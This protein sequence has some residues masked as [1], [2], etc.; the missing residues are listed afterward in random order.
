[1][2]TRSKTLI[3]IPPG[4]TIKEQLDERNLTQKEFASRMEMSEKHISKLI[5]GEVQLTVDMAIRLEMV[6]GIPAQFWLNLESIYREKLAKIELENKLDE[7]KEIASKFPYKEMVEVGFV[8]KANSMVDKVLSLRKFFEVT[9][10]GLLFENQKL[11]VVYRKL[12]ENEKSDYAL[13][14]WAQKAKVLARDIYTKP[15]HFSKLEKCMPEFRKMTKKRP[16]EFLSPLKEM[17][18]QCGVALILLPHIG[19]SFL[20]GATFKDGNKIVLG[21]T[22]RAKNADRFWFSFFHELGH[23]MLG[24]IEKDYQKEMENDA[25]EFAKD[26]LIPKDE[27]MKFVSKNDFSERSVLDFANQVNID[28]G[29]VIGRLQK[30][31]YIPFSKMNHLKRQYDENTMYYPLV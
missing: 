15:I 18:S 17:L 3:A 26:I 9:R 21:L 30:E 20:Q 10:L 24:H 7:E 2:I 29:I 5:N 22:L 25:D 8:E 6:L 1:M 19:G 4:Y 12:G 16:E 14:A 23:I 11:N 27:Y 31:G 13:M 28:Y